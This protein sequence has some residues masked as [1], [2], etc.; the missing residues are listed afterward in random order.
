MKKAGRP[1]LRAAGSVWGLIASVR[2][3]AHGPN[4]GQRYGLESNSS[5]RQRRLRGAVRER[6]PRPLPILG[7]SWRAFLGPGG[8]R[9]MLKPGSQTPFPTQRARRG[10]E[11]RPVTNKNPGK[12]TAEGDGV[13]SHARS[14]PRPFYRTMNPRAGRRSTSSRPPRLVALPT[15][16]RIEAKDRSCN[17][18]ES[19]ECLMSVIH[20]C[21]G[22]RRQPRG[23]D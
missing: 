19:L 11:R 22:R 8:R 18:E 14:P 13:P 23:T 2:A 7:R 9:R 10:R 15:C 12:P 5:F 21:V 4:R 20:G 6:A 3:S 16:R 17:M 1:I